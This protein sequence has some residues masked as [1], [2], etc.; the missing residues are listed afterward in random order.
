VMWGGGHYLLAVVVG[1]LVIALIGIVEWKSFLKRLSG[2][3]L[4]ADWLADVFGIDQRALMKR[5]LSPL[6]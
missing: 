4:M 1:A 3:E 6:L 5:S 2:Q